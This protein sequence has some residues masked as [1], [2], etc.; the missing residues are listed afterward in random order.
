MKLATFVIITLTLIVSSSPAIVNPQVAAAAAGGSIVISRGLE[1]LWLIDAENGAESRIEIQGE[2]PAPPYFEPTWSPDGSRIVFR[3]YATGMWMVN[4][5]GSGLTRL[6]DEVGSERQPTWSPDGQQI[7]FYSTSGEGN[8]GA[9]GI[10]VINVDG[11]P[12][13]NG[14]SRKHLI[15]TGNTPH[16]SPD[17]SRIAFLMGTSKNI[18]VMNSDGLDARRLEQ[19]TNDTLTSSVRWSPDGSRLLYSSLEGI[20]T[21]DANGSNNRRVYRSFGTT[22]PVWSPDG[23]YI[24]YI[25]GSGVYRLRVG[26]TALTQLSGARPSTLDWTGGS[27]GGQPPSPDPDDIPVVLVHGLDDTASSWDVYKSRF[28]P[29]IRRVG[30]AVGDGQLGSGSLALDTAST[31]GVSIAENARR[32]GR[33]IQLVKQATGAQQVDI[34]AHSMGGLISRYYIAYYMNQQNPD[35]RQ[36]IMLGTPNGGSYTAALGTAIGI[37]LYFPV[38]GLGKPLLELTPEYLWSFNKSTTDRRF[39]IPFHVLA[40]NYVVNDMYCIDFYDSPLERKPR[41]GIVSVSSAFAIPIDTGVVYPGQAGCF[42]HHST[43]F[44]S[45]AGQ[46]I[47]DNFVSLLLQSETESVLPS[48]NAALNSTSNDVFVKE[49]DSLQTTVFQT[50]I[51][52]PGNNLEFLIVQESTSEA[53]F[54]VFGNPDQM[55]INL[56]DP[57]GQIFTPTTDASGVIFMPQGPF[58]LMEG[59][60]IQDPDDG[61]WTVIVEPNADTPIDGIEVAAF[62]TYTS[63]SRLTVPFDVSEVP[64]PGDELLI[65]GKLYNADTPIIGASVTALLVAPDGVTTETVLLDDGNNGDQV[66]NDGI[67]SYTFNA[68]LPG[69]YSAS[70]EARGEQDGVPFSRSRLWVMEVISSSDGSAPGSRTLFLPT[71]IR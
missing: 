6:F 50:G 52:I 29:S 2:P 9:G 11:S 42:G 60:S 44:R 63:D 53:S 49:L 24:A 45:F 23:A 40:G 26:T 20:F 54:I 67:Y 32:L 41:D 31:T 33:Y 68:N 57:S 5:D 34:V 7:A 37:A 38:F 14:S 43:M 36:L 55:T 16:W 51:L 46:T 69:L 39:G 27:G 47:F 58:G 10:Y 56:R 30:Y 59:Y 18:Y 70:I 3:T 62:S 12:F 15:C 13:P 1:G 35:I 65:I 21:I 64:T 25:G 22:H 28:L 71:V 8:C 4:R 66:A 48:S 19:A 61:T 17:G